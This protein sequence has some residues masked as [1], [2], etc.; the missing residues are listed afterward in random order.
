LYKHFTEIKIMDG[1]MG[2]K[3]VQKWQDQAFRGVF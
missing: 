1:A 2:R 3:E